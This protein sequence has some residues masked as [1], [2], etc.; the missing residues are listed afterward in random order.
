MIWLYR[1]WCLSK[2]VWLVGSFRSATDYP[3]EHAAVIYI[4]CIE[5]YGFVNVSF[6]AV[7]AWLGE[8]YIWRDSLT[9]AISIC[10]LS[11]NLPIK[12]YQ[13]V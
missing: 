8:S 9:A 7:L 2:R 6:E 11:C 10:A 5:S 1:E 3:P 12:E 13:L 4:S